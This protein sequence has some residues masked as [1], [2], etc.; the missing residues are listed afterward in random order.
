[1]DRRI[2]R[3]LSFSGMVQG[4]GFRYRAEYAARYVGASGWVRNEYDGTVT[5]E[6][7]ATPEQIEQVIS[8][9]NEGRYVYIESIEGKTI[10]VIPNESDFR[11]RY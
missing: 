10:P 4:V 2:R 9:I 11:V 6:I 8:L 1:M 3:R 7:Q 5:M